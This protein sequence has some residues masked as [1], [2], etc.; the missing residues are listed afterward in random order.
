MTFIRF[1]DED[2]ER[3]SLP[4]WVDWDPLDIALVDLEELSERFEF[5]LIDW[6]EVFY[7]RIPFE[8]AGR[9]D[10]QRVAP[11]WQA[12][13]AMWMALHRAGVQ[14]SWEDAGTIRLGRTFSRQDESPG[15]AP[16]TDEKPSDPS[17]ASTTPPSETSSA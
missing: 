11:K 14:A 9:E 4:E 6:P 13:A 2:R 5:E 17:G 10:A 15:K 12:R 8:Q 1:P 7:G 16:E 3:W